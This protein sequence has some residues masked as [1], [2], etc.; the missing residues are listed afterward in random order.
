M[1]LSLA[2]Q[3]EPRAMEF[4]WVHLTMLSLYRFFSALCSCPFFNSTSFPL[5]IFCCVCASCLPMDPRLALWRT[6]GVPKGIVFRT[7]ICRSDLGCWPGPCFVSQNR[8]QYWTLSC[9]WLSKQSRWSYQNLS[10]LLC[11][12]GT[13]AAARA[14]CPLCVGLS[15]TGQTPRTLSHSQK[16]EKTSWLPLSMYLPRTEVWA[17]GL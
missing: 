17:H 2:T 9:Y 15:Q 6:I 8:L 16:E 5:L 11:V 7:H 1:A 13:R 4:D 3:P 12:P 14:L 10:P